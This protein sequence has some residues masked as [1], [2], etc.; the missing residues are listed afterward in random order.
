MSEPVVAPYGGLM[1]RTVEVEKEKETK[2]KEQAVTVQINGQ[3]EVVRPEAIFIRGVDSL[4]TE[5]IKAFV[6]YYV[7]YDVVSPEYGD[8]SGKIR[9]EP[10]PVDEQ[11]KF[12]VQWVNDSSVNIAFEDFEKVVDA[13]RKISTVQSNPN[14]PKTEEELAEEFSLAN[15]IQ[16]RETKPFNPII[17]FK[18]HTDLKSRLGIVENPTAQEGDDAVDSNGAIEA[19]TGMDEDESSVVLYCRQS[20]QSDRKVKG[21][22]TYSRYYLLHGEPERRPKNKYRNR[23]SQGGRRERGRRAAAAE[24]QEEE[25]DLF[26]S[27]IRDRDSRDRSRSRSRSPVRMELDR[28]ENQEEEEDLFASKFRR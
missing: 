6:D 25:E 15:N 24:P 12:R 27:R 11:I 23:D 4:S 10:H 5:D 14:I 28:R 9:Y 22:A 7:N 26:A 8:E 19:D 20:F 16:E 13:L 17:Q 3:E 2:L 18:K 21:A 1:T